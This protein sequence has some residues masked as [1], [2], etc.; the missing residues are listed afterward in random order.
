ML[1]WMMGTK[2]FEKIRAEEIRMTENMAN[3]SEKTREAILRWLGHV[4]RTTEED[5]VIR[6][7]K[8]EVNGH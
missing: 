6:T 2:R 1:R 4:E 3:I 8:M 5:V 7:R